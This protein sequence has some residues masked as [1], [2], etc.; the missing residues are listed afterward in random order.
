MPVRVQQFPQGLRELLG[1][2]DPPQ[3]FTFFPE[4]LLPI[5]DIEAFLLLANREKNS[6]I[7]S[8]AA[9]PSTGAGIIV[10]S[11]ELW[12]LHLAQSSTDFL[13]ADQEVTFRVA[14]AIDGTAQS[15]PPVT[16]L[17]TFLGISE[18]L[19]TPQHDLILRPGDEIDTRIDAITV[20]VAGS[21]PMNT[22]ILFSRL[23]P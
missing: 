6:T 16:T 1:R 3:P 14:V 21:I 10:P 20:G 7:E 18:W 5:I 4:S 22:R 23:A 19:R 9:A 15:A 8:I 12:V 11:G 17:A 2:G 13:D